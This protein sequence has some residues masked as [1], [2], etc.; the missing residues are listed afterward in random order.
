VTTLLYPNARLPTEHIP[1]L[2]IRAD[3]EE[4]VEENGPGCGE[5]QLAVKG[6]KSGRAQPTE[7]FQGIVEV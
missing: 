7:H 1:P 6:P 3:C 4:A 5:E 2:A